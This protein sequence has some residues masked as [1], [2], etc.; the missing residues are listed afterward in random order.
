MFLWMGRTKPLLLSSQGSWAFEYYCFVLLWGN[1][2]VH[3]YYFFLCQPQIFP[4]FIHEDRICAVRRCW[5]GTPGA[6][7]TVRTS[8]SASATY[9]QSTVACPTYLRG[10]RL[11]LVSSVPHPVKGHLPTNLKCA[12]DAGDYQLDVSP[13]LIPW[14]RRKGTLE[15][16]LNCV[17][18]FQP[19][20]S[21][22]SGIADGRLGWHSAITPSVCDIIC[23]M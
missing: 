17:V 14:P 18:P 9:L 21:A 8:T 5:L 1:R 23:W 7:F 20:W 12:S 13:G 6:L 3:R 19:A 16:S 15:A 22:K 11:H 2:R 10:P 4:L